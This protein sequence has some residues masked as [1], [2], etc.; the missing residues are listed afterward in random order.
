MQLV[1]EQKKNQNL[2]NLYQWYINNRRALRKARA[3]MLLKFLSINISNSTFKPSF[4][5]NVLF[6]LAECGASVKGSEGTLLSPNFPSNY[7]NNHE[8]IYKIETEAGKGIRLRA[9][10]FQL[11]E[12]DTLKVRG[13]SLTWPCLFLSR[14]TVYI[15]PH[16]WIDTDTH[17]QSYLFIHTHFFS[18]F[19]QLVWEEE[20]QC[21]LVACVWTWKHL[22]LKSGSIF[23]SCVSWANYLTFFNLNFWIHEK[24]QGNLPLGLFWGWNNML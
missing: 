15:Q 16:T 19:V 4:L 1:H 14:N 20:I 23:I 6:I 12:G 17:M 8:C 18:L 7:D 10:S 24:V 2:T 13:S 22:S 9:Q 11:F 21:H 3:V 5:F